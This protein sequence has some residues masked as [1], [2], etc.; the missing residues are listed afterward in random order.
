MY[1]EDLQ[2]AVY[3]S[4]NRGYDSMTATV[5]NMDDILA[6]KDKLNSA[7]KLSENLYANDNC[8]HFK[9]CIYF[10]NRRR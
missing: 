2:N 1:D 6:N 8:S 7:F 10:S 3:H 5:K 9:K 4:R